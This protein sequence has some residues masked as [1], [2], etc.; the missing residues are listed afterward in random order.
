MS[1]I[2]ERRDKKVSCAG[3]GFSQLTRDSTVGQ[4]AGCLGQQGVK[5]L[6]LVFMLKTIGSFFPVVSSQCDAE[7][8]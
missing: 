7:F 3:G 8:R 5:R 1:L 2:G 4:L 6:A